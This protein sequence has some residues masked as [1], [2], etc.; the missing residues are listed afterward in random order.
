M[1]DSAKTIADLPAADLPLASTAIIEVQVGTGAGSSQKVAHADLP[2]S[3]ATQSALDNKADL[4][5]GV[6]PSS[7]IPA[8]AITQ[9]LGNVASEAAM[10]ALAGEMGDWCIRTDD[11]V[12]TWVITGSDPTSLGSWTQ[13]SVPAAPVSTVNGQTGTV[14]LGKGDVGLGN[15]D[16][17]SDV[18]KPVSTAQQAALDAKLASSAV[19]SFGLTLVDDADA[20]TARGTLGVAASEI[21]QNSK[22]AAYTLVLAD[23][24]K[25]ILHP[26]ADTTARTFTIPANSSVAYPIGTAL[27]FVNQNGAGVLTI[28]ITTD[29]M[30]LAGAGTTG[31]RTLAANGIATAIKLTS[32]EW[33]ISGVGLT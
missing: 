16:N 9:F 17:T 31:S 10:L 6:V 3:D 21:L 8:I 12:A 24:A 29:T 2:I 4:V 32:T 11:P 28:A 23:S 1:T 7:Q 33:I 15:A 30:R 20:A 19:S 26:S 25:H 13:V 18:N 27:T 22:S 5:G 14:V